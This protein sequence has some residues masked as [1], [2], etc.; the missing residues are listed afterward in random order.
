MEPA[1]EA[2]P[3]PY[4]AAGWPEPK[5]PTDGMAVASLVTGLLALGP[6][7]VVL[8]LL[9]F[10][11]IRRH[12]R[13]GKGFAVAG[14]VL[15]LLGTLVWVAVGA[16]LLLTY[17][18]TQPLPADVSERQEANAVQL[19][20][21]NCIESLTPDGQVGTV[22]VVP[23]SEP[24]EAQVTSEYQF[25]DE[26]WPGRARAVAAVWRSCVLTAEELEAQA[27]SVTWVPT[28]ESWDSGDRTGL[29]LAVYPDA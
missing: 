21:G 29:C 20:P 19:V 23:C 12:G 25:A 10:R 28:K 13:S 14:L 3:P 6:V 2:Y 5:P 16:V 8:A 22:V 9:G 27:V 18:G 7:A 26:R 1:R 24:H 15:G 4:Y 17:T 11:R